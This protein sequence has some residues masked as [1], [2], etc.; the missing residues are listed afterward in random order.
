MN[1]IGRKT[2]YRTVVRTSKWKQ[3]HN[4]TLWP[5]LCHHRMTLPRPPPPPYHT[6]ASWAP[7]VQRLRQWKCRWGGEGWRGTTESLWFRNLSKMQCG[8]TTLRLRAAKPDNLGIRLLTIIYSEPKRGSW[9]SFQIMW[10]CK[11]AWRAGQGEL[12]SRGTAT[13]K[14]RT[15]N[16]LTVPYTFPLVLQ[17]CSSLI[18]LNAHSQHYS[19]VLFQYLIRLQCKLWSPIHTSYLF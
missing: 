3:R 18:T 7:S 19:K 14:K 15:Y 1:A 16:Q 8:S 11:Q 13:E 5:L 12:R 4:F 2:G 9:G 6:P 17:V 10:A